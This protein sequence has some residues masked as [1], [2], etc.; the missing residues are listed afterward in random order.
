MFDHGSLM[1][2]YTDDV[3]RYLLNDGPPDFAD[4]DVEAP[5]GWFAILLPT[6]EEIAHA[7]SITGSPRAGESGVFVPGA[8]Y[9]VRQNH[10]GIVWAFEYTDVDPQSDESVYHDFDRAVDA[11]NAWSNREDDLD[12][13]SSSITPRN[14]PY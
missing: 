7:V 14:L 1:P 8:A 5:T 13:R 11:F 9:G 2:S 12:A 6:R 3:I 10:E 4:G